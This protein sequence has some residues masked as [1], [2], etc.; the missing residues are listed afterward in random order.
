MN[1]AICAAGC[2]R[3]T[4]RPHSS[5]RAPRSKRGADDAETLATAGFAIGLV[6]HDYEAAM[7]AIERGLK[8]NGTSVGGAR[9]WSH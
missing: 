2:R 3:W 5:M 4:K 6:S 1:S 8:I 9:L 7:N